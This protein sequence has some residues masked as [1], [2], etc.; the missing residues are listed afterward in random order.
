MQHV[1][2]GR[3]ALAAT[4][5]QGKARQGKAWAARAQMQKRDQPNH[6]TSCQTSHQTC[7]DEGATPA[8]SVQATPSR[9]P[10]GAVP[11]SLTL[12]LPTLAHS[13]LARRK[14]C[15]YAELAR[16]SYRAE[17]YGKLANSTVSRCGPLCG[18]IMV[19][20]ASRFG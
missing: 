15:R 13:K 10:P 20:S 3:N 12:T 8:C 4:R 11:P 7:P 2:Q 19:P 17:G 5:R 18:R 14:E 1:D 16:P 6:H 9:W